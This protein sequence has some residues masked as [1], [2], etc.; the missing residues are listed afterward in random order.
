MAFTTFNSTNNTFVQL[1]SPDNAPNESSTTP[2]RTGDLIN[3]KINLKKYS[4]AYFLPLNEAW[5]F[6][7]DRARQS[8]TAAAV[9]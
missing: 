4:R 9:P 8:Q 6:I 5:V 7:P 1:V 2:T 3:S